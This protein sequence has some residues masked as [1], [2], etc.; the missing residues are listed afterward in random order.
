VFTAFVT[1][2]IEWQRR[3]FY[4]QYFAIDPVLPYGRDT[5]SPFDWES[6][7]GGRDDIVDFFADADRHNVG[8]NGFSIPVRNRKNSCA[9]VSFTNN[10]SRIEREQ[11]KIDNMVKLKHLSALID[12]AATVGAK[13]PDSPNV[14]LSLREEQCLMWAARGKTYEAIS[15]ILNLSFH[16]V[17]NHLDIARHKLHG[18]NLT[19]AVAVAVALGVIPEII[20][21]DSYG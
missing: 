9:L 17:R 6:L 2:S 1:Y 19:H 20:L 3:Y 21:R 10:L 18:V 5:S 13:L 7:V 8:R 16:S 4:K 15:Q 12:A 14:K 11:F